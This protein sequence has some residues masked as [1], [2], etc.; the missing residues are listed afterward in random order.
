MNVK[1]FWTKRCW[2]IGVGV[3]ARVGW[4]RT[5]RKYRRTACRLAEWG[6]ILS[7]TLM[8]SASVGWAQVRH[9]NFITASAFFFSVVLKPLRMRWMRIYFLHIMIVPKMLSHL[10]FHILSRLL[11]SMVRTAVSAN[12]ESNESPRYGCSCG[13]RLIRSVVWQQCFDRMVLSSHPVIESMCSACN[14][15]ITTRNLS[16]HFCTLRPTAYA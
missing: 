10:S 3:G 13:R 12:D 2:F 9:W 16:T 6:S 5:K 7:L 14:N 15:H 11:D 1:R 4:A 8:H